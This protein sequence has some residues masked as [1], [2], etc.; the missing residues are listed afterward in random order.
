[1][2]D[3]SDAIDKYREAVQGLPSNKADDAEERVLKALLARDRVAFELAHSAPLTHEL[4]IAT[5]A[6]D[7]KLK[8]KVTEIKSVVGPD[9]LAEWRGARL[10]PAPPAGRTQDEYWWWFLDAQAGGTG[11]D[12][13]GVRIITFLIW[14]VVVISLSFIIESV[15]RFLSGEVSVLG[16]VLQGIVTLMVGS[17]ILQFAGQLVAARAPR[18]KEEKAAN[19]PLGRR[20]LFPASFA[21]VALVMWFLLPWMV[22]FYSDRGVENQYEGQLSNPISYYQRTISLE[23]SDAIAHYNLARA[24]EAIAEFDKAESEYKSA[25]RWDD[26]QP[27]AYD[28]L[29]R[30][31]LDG[32]KD[33]ANALRLLNTG[34]AKLEA[35]KDAH[36]FQNEDDYKRIKVSLLKHRAWAYLGLESFTQAHDDLLVAAALR[37]NAA[38]HCLLGQV[39]EKEQGLLEEEQ[40]SRGQRPKLKEEIQQ[41]KGQ[42]RQAYKDCVALSANQQER[43][44]PDWMAH[45]QESLNREDQRAA[46]DDA[47]KRSGRQRP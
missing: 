39:L 2:S 19:P 5:A 33:Y 20:L 21:A 14:G 26:D 8:A 43:I 13:P 15:R 37:Q 11:D 1:M 24:Y 16:T 9:R 32:K 34:L 3:I 17:S 38:S 46:R 47:E 18:P 25:I 12:R 36:V 4:L 28:G 44:E 22:R 45:A 30:L 10:P 23:P 27:V 7:R 35:Q 41:L 31:L 29:A 40:K 6:I 42:I